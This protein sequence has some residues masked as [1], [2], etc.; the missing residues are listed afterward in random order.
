MIDRSSSDW[1]DYYKWTAHRPPRRTTLTALAALPEKSVGTTSHALDLGAGAGRDTAPMLEAGLRVLAIDT[2]PEAGPTL[3][4]RFPEPWRDGRLTFKVA[5]FAKDDL[6]L[7]FATL[8]NASFCLPMCPS[9]RFDGLWNSINSAL[10][11]G[12]LFA[13]HLYGPRDSWARRGDG[14]TIH[15]RN[16]AEA[17]FAAWRVLLFEEEES[18]SITPRGNLKHWHVFHIVAHKSRAEISTP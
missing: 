12:G 13:G 2:A 7:P 9:R 11:P 18:D 10:A 8:I 15:T 17:L 16:D 3:K 1:T 5:D 6:D 4:R 14:L